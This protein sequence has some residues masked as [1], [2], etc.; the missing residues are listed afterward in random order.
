M[1]LRVYLLHQAMLS[2]ETKAKNLWLVAPIELG[3][4]LRQRIE[5]NAWDGEWYRRACRR[6][7]GASNR[8]ATQYLNPGLIRLDKLS[9]VLLVPGSPDPCSS[10]VEAAACTLRGRKSRL[11]FCLRTGLMLTSRGNSS[12]PV[13]AIS[14]SD[15]S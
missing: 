13:F 3:G 6:S 9:V 10:I 14:P 11:R 1:D 15:P 8:G 7:T 12:S 2:A 4:Q 5:R